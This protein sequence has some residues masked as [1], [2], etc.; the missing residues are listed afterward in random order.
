VPH[1]EE[2][3]PPQE[4][5]PI[6]AVNPVLSLARQE[7]HEMARWDGLPHFGQSAFSSD[8]LMGRKSSNFE[9]HSRQTYS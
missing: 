6:G 9:P 5:P 4:L 7:K 1:E 2:L 3:H 8:W